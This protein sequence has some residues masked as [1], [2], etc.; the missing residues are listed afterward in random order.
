V[1]IVFDPHGA[2]LA[3][4]QGWMAAATGLDG[5]LLVGGDDVL[6]VVERLSVPHP[7]VEV[8]HPFRLHRKVGVA[9]GNPGPVP[10]GFDRVVGEDATH[11]GRRDRVDDPAGDD[12]EGEVQTAPPGQR[13]TL[14]GGQFAG[15]RFDL[16]PLCLG[17][18]SGAPGPG[19]V[20]Q[21]GH[22]LAGEPGPPFP[23]G[24]DWDREPE[25]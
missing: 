12:I 14:R 1:V 22:S 18:P 5:G 25:K 10:P 9:H 23:G 24:V 20:G 15:Q 7:G 13:H 2:G 3:R 11:G 8:E 6:V 4:G 16:D 19:E 17:E 21:T